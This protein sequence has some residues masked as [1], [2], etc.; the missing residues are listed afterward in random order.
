M[1]ELEIQDEQDIRNKASKMKSKQLV[2]TFVI[3][4]SYK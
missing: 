3:L 2:S 4:Y 1:N